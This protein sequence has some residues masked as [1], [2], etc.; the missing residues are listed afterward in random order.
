[1][2]AK[3]HRP[4]D[5]YLVGR[6][7]KYGIEQMTTESINAIKASRLV[8]ETSGDPDAVRS[9]HG[10][11][12]DMDS[13]YWTGELCDDVYAR[14][15]DTILDEVKKNGPTVAVITDGHPMLFD[16]VNWDLLHKGR[17][18]GLNVVALPAVG[19]LDTMSI[20]VGMDLGAG[21]Q[22]VGANHM[23]LYDI[24]LDPHMQ[25]YVLQV[26]KFGTSF[27]SRETKRNRPGRF[28]PLVRHLTR[29]YPAD[30]VVT[31]I[32]SLGEESIRRRVRLGE[33]DSARAFIHAQ[34]NNGLT[35][36]IPPVPGEIVNE[37]FSRNV[38]DL[39]YLARIAELA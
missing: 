39:E 20:D 1:M 24:K 33:L 12:I 29:F 31:L 6:G 35:M 7:V 22:I 34:E 5:L 13:D 17:R 10:N 27:Y 32:V 37:E 2:T 26:A 14:M 18:R 21:A 16:D 11:V 4:V 9:I 36:H 23:V 30:I 8:F 28:A 25:T 15:A 19:C 38:D 3:K